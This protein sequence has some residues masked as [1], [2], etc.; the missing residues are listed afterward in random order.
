MIPA[1]LYG[2]AITEWGKSSQV[3]VAIEELAELIKE[4]VKLKRYPNS[5][6][7]HLIEEIADVKIM[8]AQLE[9]IF[10]I[11]QEDIDWYTDTKLSRLAQ[12][13]GVEKL[14]TEKK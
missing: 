2:L 4:L 11:K 12:R 10:S 3:D 5:N 1:D 13:L 14:W 6:I 9:G 8:I 7:S